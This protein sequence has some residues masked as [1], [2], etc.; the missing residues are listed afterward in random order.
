MPSWTRCLMRFEPSQLFKQVSGYEA[1]QGPFFRN[2]VI[3]S[4]SIARDW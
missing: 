4:E 2:S 3:L 1:I